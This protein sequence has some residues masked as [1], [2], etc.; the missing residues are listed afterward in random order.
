MSFI[1]F[2]WVEIHPMVD[3]D[4]WI[5]VPGK[6]GGVSWDSHRNGLVT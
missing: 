4:Q 1:P 3:M 6:A 2:F 5:A